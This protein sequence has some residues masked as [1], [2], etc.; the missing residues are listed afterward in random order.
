MAKVCNYV[1]FFS[2][3]F[4]QSSHS[5]KMGPA[6]SDTKFD[7]SRNNKYKYSPLLINLH[8]RKY[9]YDAVA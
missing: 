6:A 2:I 4:K 8:D 7:A 1:F 9:A 3:D 5:I